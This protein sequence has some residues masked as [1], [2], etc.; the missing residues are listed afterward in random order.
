MQVIDEV[1]K[2]QNYSDQNS[3][4]CFWVC[5]SCSGW[6]LISAVD[7]MMKVVAAFERHPSSTD[8]RAFRV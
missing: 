2:W 8:P 7:W 3:D 4:C 1:Y 6:P 5:L